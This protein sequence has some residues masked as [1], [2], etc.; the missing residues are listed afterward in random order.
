MEE[1][2]GEEEE[3]HTQVRKFKWRQAKCKCCANNRLR[4]F[5]RS[6]SPLLTMR[7]LAAKG[8]DLVGPADWSRL[9][10]WA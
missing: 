7:S 10:R 4:P 9:T 3:R 6:F 2:G 1:R 5:L 8:P